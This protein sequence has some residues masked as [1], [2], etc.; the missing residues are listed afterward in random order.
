MSDDIEDKANEDTNDANWWFKSVL[1]LNDFRVE[2]EPLYERKDRMK[3]LAKR[4]R[5]FLIS[6]DGPTAVEYADMLALIIIVCITAIQSVGTR[7]NAT[8]N[9]VAQQLPAAS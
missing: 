5:D 7:A 8:F 3:L 9:Q 2:K 6:E 4:V 1:G